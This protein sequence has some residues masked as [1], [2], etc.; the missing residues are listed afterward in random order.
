LKESVAVKRNLITLIGVVAIIAG[1]V[2]VRAAFE[3]TIQTEEE[4]RQAAEAAHNLEEAEELTKEAVA[5][6]TA[7]AESNVVEAAT[8]DEAPGDAAPA[9]TSLDAFEDI[10]WAEA[11]PETFYV[12][13]ETTAGAFVIQSHQKWAPI[14]HE[15]FYEL[16]KTGFFNDSGFYRVI[17]DFMV[18]FGLAADPKLT[19]QF[20]QKS[21]R[22]E[23]VRKSNQRGKVTFAKSAQPN[24]RTTQ[25]FINY[26]DNSRLDADGFAPF[27]EVVVGMENV[28]TISDEYGERPNQGMI[29]DEGT[30]YL[31]AKYPGL[32]F[33]NKVTLVQVK[34]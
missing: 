14:G 19:A 20:K 21:L 30:P 11:T 16:C 7:A 12:K 31:K 9:P 1:I 2:G 8:T 33:I 23:P 10:A 22:D 6:E 25:I 13:F 32:D 24:S 29:S 15:R 34:P 26:A 17:H 3:Q 28:D 5:E 18:Q 27:A 4:A